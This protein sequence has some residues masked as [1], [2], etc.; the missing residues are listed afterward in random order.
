MLADEATR[1]MF[2]KY[3]SPLDFW[4]QYERDNKLRYLPLVVRKVLAIPAMAAA[5]E[6]NHSTLHD[7]VTKER[8]SLE[9]HFAGQ[10]TLNAMRARQRFDKK[11]KTTNYFSFGQILTDIILDDDWQPVLDE[12]EEVRAEIDEAEPETV[13][14]AEAEEVNEAEVAGGGEREPST[15]DNGEPYIVF[16]DNPDYDSTPKYFEHPALGKVRQR[17]RNSLYWNEDFLGT[18]V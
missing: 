14:E 13:A 7:V 16:E 8:S 10:L 15:N 9:R 18:V 5:A 1:R 2:V 3:D 6:R 4:E 12:A 11:K 17:K